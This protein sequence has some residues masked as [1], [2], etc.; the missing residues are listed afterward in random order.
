[1]KVTGVTVFLVDEGID[2]G[3]IV[4][5]EAIEVRDDDDWSSLEARVLSRSNTG[6]CLA[7][8]GRWSRAV[9]WSTVGT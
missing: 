2:T 4:L 5:Q 1:M 3:P 6:C 8:F 7:P 9:S